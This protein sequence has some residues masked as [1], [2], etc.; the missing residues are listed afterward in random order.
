MDS[1]LLDWLILALVTPFL[2][3]AVVLLYGFVGCGLDV[4][5]SAPATPKAPTD[6]RAR[7][8]GTTTVN[9]RWQDNSGGGVGFKFVRFEEGA[10]GPPV[11]GTFGGSPAD[12]MANLHEGTTYFY[13]LR[14]TLPTGDSD[15]SNESGATTFPEA[16]VDLKAIP[17]DVNRIDLYWTNKSAKAKKVIVQDESGGTV[18]E[19]EFPKDVPQPLQRPV[20]EGSAHKYRILA[21]VEGFQ[22]SVAEKVRSAP[23]P[24]VPA[25]PLAFKA[26]LTA[27]Q[28]NLQGFCLIQRI[29][30]TQL[31]NHGRLSKITLLG[32]GAGSLTID[33]IYVSQPAAPPGNP[34]DAHSDLTK[35]LNKDEGDPPLVLPANSS[36]TLDVL[37]PYDL[38]PGKNL[39]VA[40]DF[41]P[42]AGQGT[43]RFAPTPGALLY[44]RA[45]TQQAAVANRYPNPANPTLTFNT[46]T[47]RHYLV[48]RIEV[49]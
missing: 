2:I 13:K 49:S 9:L 32:P 38:L 20:A 7:G 1:F 29:A 25:K 40:L 3:V 37:V 14:A 30:S 36:R 24:A 11:T 10:S 19:D 43:V 48:E 31:K 33:R 34:W 15:P 5:G 28:P 23:L 35:V 21:F 12:D 8:T 41:N 17:E 42:A 16:P 26:V 47:D 39:L 18:T 4:T 27:D 46:G 22:E 45:A 6:L 44:A